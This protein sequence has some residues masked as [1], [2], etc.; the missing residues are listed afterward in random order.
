[1]AILFDWYE[2]PKPSDKRGNGYNKKVP[3]A[4]ALARI[5][6]TSLLYSSFI[7]CIQNLGA[8]YG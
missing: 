1:M 6:G 7:R 8:I 5:G 2:D 3:P 4:L